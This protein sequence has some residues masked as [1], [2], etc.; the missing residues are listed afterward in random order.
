MLKPEQKGCVPVLVMEK[1]I[2]VAGVL[3]CCCHLVRER[4]V[5][6]CVSVHRRGERG[7]CERDVCERDVCSAAVC[8]LRYFCPSRE[9]AGGRRGLSW[10]AP[11]GR[12][13]APR[14]RA[15]AL[16]ALNAPMSSSR[17][18]SE[19]RGWTARRGR[20]P[21]Q[22]REMEETEAA[23]HRVVEDKAALCSW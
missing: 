7:E 22:H 17:P 21:P 15:G 13:R 18:C 5:V 11:R 6:L 10:A 20:T 19:R 16:P 2:R 14:A 3:C 23:K 8:L 12:R 9:R 4:A 1:K